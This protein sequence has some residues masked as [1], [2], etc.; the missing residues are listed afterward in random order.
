MKLLAELGA[1]APP[2]AGIRAKGQAAATRKDRE[3]EREG[4]WDLFFV[5]N[6]D[7]K[8]TE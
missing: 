2:A 8:R 1:P 5:S 3:E 7:T 6:H 4:V